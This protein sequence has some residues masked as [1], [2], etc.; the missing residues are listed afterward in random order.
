MGERKI[1]P[2]EFFSDIM[3]AIIGKLKS[4]SKNLQTCPCTIGHDKKKETVWAKIETTGASFIVNMPLK[5][6]EVKM[7]MFVE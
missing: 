6:S 1:I 5:L 4:G 3:R 2:G 7:R